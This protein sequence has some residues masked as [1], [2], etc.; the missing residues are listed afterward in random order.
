MKGLGDIAFREITGI[1]FFLHNDPGIIA[2]PPVQLPFADIH[3]IDP[4][5]PMLEHTVGKASGGGPDIRTDHARYVQ[6]E[7]LKGRVQFPTPAT[8]KFIA[9]RYLNQ[10]VRGTGTTGFVRNLP[11]HPHG[12]GQNQALGLF[13][14]LGKPALNKHYIQSLF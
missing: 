9:G 12:S 2:E 1:E 3:G 10:R 7:G 11:I 6:V 8:D 5:C 14:A 4:G 13:P